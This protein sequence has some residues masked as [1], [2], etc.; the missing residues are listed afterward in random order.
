[1]TAVRHTPARRRAACPACGRD[2]SYTHPWDLSG[3][4][5]FRDYTTRVFKAHH[6]P[7]GKPCDVNGPHGFG[8]AS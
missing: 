2:V 3:G 8:V 6:T 4:S 1:M 5:H 7:A